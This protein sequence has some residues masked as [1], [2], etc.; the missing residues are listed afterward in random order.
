VILLPRER[1]IQ[2]VPAAGAAQR[3]LA[4]ER[5]AARERIKRHAMLHQFQQGGFGRVNE[6]VVAGGGGPSGSTTTWSPTDKTSTVSLS[7]SN[8]IATFPNDGNNKAIR[9]SSYYL[10]GKRYWEV[11]VTT[12]GG[13]GAA[14]IK[15]SDASLAAFGNQAMWTSDGSMAVSAGYNS[16]ANPG[17]YTTSDILMFA[18]E[19]VA[20]S[21][22]LYCGKNGTFLNSANP[23]A[24]TG[25]Q[26]DGSDGSVTWGAC[27]NLGDFLAQKVHTLNCG[28]TA[29]AY[30]PP[31]GFSAL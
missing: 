27:S 6:P 22:R 19:F 21:F 25:Y 14:G 24:G 13:G 30:T 3:F 8:Y 10:T 7:G 1:Q 16:N 2:V 23:A 31:S 12:L 9:S 26:A 29:F 5:R 18:L 28:A 17:A 20:G 4:E 15:R 11:P